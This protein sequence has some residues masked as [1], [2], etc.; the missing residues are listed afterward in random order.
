MIRTLLIIAVAG[1]AIAL[2]SFGGFVSLG[3]IQAAQRGDFDFGTDDWGNDRHHR[4]DQGPV[5]TRTVAWAGTDTLQVDLAA[6][7]TFTQGAQAGIT[8]SGPQR[9]VDQ[10]V[11]E[12]GRIRLTDGTH[13]LRMGHRQRLKITVTAPAVTRFVINGSPDVAIVGYDHPS[14]AIDISGSGDVNAV[15]KASDLDL[16]IAGSGDVDLS[17]L[18]LA[19]AK[20][21]IAGSGDA[22]LSPTASAAVAIAGSG[23]VTLLTRPPTLTS[24]ISGSGDLDVGE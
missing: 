22:I 23:D 17:G 1:A 4:P 9:V 20:V 5:V 3:G 11:V 15:G 8:I 6:D 16:S 24:D 7:V 21:A 19:T 10:V 12:G 2:L 18:Q 13:D 14:M